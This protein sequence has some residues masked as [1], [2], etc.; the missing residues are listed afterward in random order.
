MFAVKEKTV[1]VAMYPRD[2]LQEMLCARTCDLARHLNDIE[3]VELL[4]KETTPQGLIRHRHHWRAR[5]NVPPLLAQHIDSK[6]LEWIGRVEWRANE[7]VS[8]WIVEPGFMRDSVVCEAVMSLS[9]AVGGRGTRLDLELDITAVRIPTGFQA[10]LGAILKTH[11][12]KLV[13][14]AAKAIENG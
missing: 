14:A 11:F 12:R 1:I 8:R 2:R 7:Y 9:P 6:V 5:A 13:D 4:S 3:S 10:I